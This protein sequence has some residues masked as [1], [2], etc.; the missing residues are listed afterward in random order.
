MSNRPLALDVRP[1]FRRP[2]ELRSGT[3]IHDLSKNVRWPMKRP[4]HA[5]GKVR[6]TR[7]GTLRYAEGKTASVAESSL[8]FESGK[9]EDVYYGRCASVAS[10]MIVKGAIRIP[11]HNVVGIIAV[12]RSNIVPAGEDDSGW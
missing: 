12:E 6:Y 11:C 7:Q 3:R 9:V 10:V 1:S 4:A 8:S 2:A 5:E